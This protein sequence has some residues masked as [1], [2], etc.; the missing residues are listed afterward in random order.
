MYD[1]VT[2]LPAAA[3]DATQPAP[4][5]TTPPVTSSAPALQRTRATNHATSA[6]HKSQRS[7]TLRRDVLKKPAETAKVGAARRRPQVGRVAKSDLISKFA[8]HPQPL[9]SKPQPRA[10]SPR[11]DI[12]PVRQKPA[13]IVSAKHALVTPAAQV[14]APAAAAHVSPKEQLIAKR[15][16]AVQETSAEQP[17]KQ[18]GSGR[19]RALSIATAS[20]AIMI[21]GGYL[22]YLNMP[23]LSVRV[24]AAQAGV[25]ASFPE[26]SPDGYRFSGPVAYAPGQVTIDFL[27]NGGTAKYTVTE[28]KSTWD[29]Q[30][31]YDNIVAKS[32]NEDYVTNSQQGLTIYTYGGGAAWVNGGILYTIKGDAPLSN[33]QLLKIAGSL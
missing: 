26:Y 22:T 10:A 16:A 23:G 24:A 30:A 2:G 13:A 9:Q 1:A 18:R 14:T 33:E 29:S 27:A 32:A 28:Q 6:H 12:T 8:P 11:L 4:I 3:P 5:E 31:V 19:S 7:K 20:F 17:K 15:L 25:A 21:I